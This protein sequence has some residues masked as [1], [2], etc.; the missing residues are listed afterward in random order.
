MAQQKE[1]SDAQAFQHENQIKYYQSLLEK[2]QGE[3]DKVQVQDNLAGVYA[4]AEEKQG[5]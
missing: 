4:A 2:Q 5:E 1:K 3:P